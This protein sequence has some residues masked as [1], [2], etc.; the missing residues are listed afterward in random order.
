MIRVYLEVAAPWVFA[1]PVDHP[2]WQRR[3]RGEDKA[4]EELETYRRRYGSAM[5]TTPRGEFEVVGTVE[6]NGTTTFGAPDARGPWDAEPLSLKEIRAVRSCWTY[7]DQTVGRV[8]AE[9]QKGP[10]GG[11]RDRDG[12]AAHVQEAE[13]TYGRAIGARVPPRTPWPEQRE[14]ILLALQDL[15]SD[16]WPAKYAARRISWH[17]L[18]HAWELEDKSLT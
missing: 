2:G 9:L 10:R 7:F 8:S 13:R 15:T 3:G 16:K 1:C 11:G 4:L 6:G 14:E 17:V 5:G 12:I 18:D